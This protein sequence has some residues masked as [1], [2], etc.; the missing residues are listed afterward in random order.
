MSG[1]TEESYPAASTN[2]KGHTESSEVQEV[3]GNQSTPQYVSGF[4]GLIADQL[5]ANRFHSVADKTVMGSR[6]SLAPPQG[7]GGSTPATANH[8]ATAKSPLPMPKGKRKRTDKDVDDV[9][10]RQNKGIK[11]GKGSSSVDFVDGSN[12]SSS[13]DQSA[14]GES[15][16]GTPGGESDHRPQKAFTAKASSTTGPAVDSDED[17]SDV[18]GETSGGR[19]DTMQAQNDGVVFPDKVQITNKGPKPN[20][21]TEDR[22]RAR[23]EVQM[24]MNKDKKNI[25][26]SV[27]EA[28]IEYAMGTVGLRA[29]DFPNVHGLAAQYLKNTNIFAAGAFSSWGGNRRLKKEADRLEFVS[30]RYPHYIVTL[31]PD[32]L[33]CLVAAQDLIPKWSDP[34]GRPI[35]IIRE[36]ELMTYLRTSVELGEGIQWNGN[37]Y[38]VLMI[39][40]R[41]PDGQCFSKGVAVREPITATRNRKGIP[42]ANRT[43]VLASVMSVAGTNHGMQPYPY[44]EQKVQVPGKVM[45]E[46]DWE[47]ENSHW[48]NNLTDRHADPQ[49]LRNHIKTQVTQDLMPIIKEEWRNRLFFWTKSNYPEFDLQFEV[50]HESQIVYHDPGVQ[51]FSEETDQTRKVIRRIEKAVLDSKP[52]PKS[53]EETKRI[54]KEGTDTLFAYRDYEMGNYRRMLDSMRDHQSDTT[55]TH[56]K[57][58]ESF[59]EN[60]SLLEEEGR[61]RQIDK[62]RS[63]EVLESDL[64]KAKQDLLATDSQGSEFRSKTLEELSEY[65]ATECNVPVEEQHQW[66]K[67]LSTM[68]S[69][70]LINKDPYKRSYGKDVPNFEVKGFL[71]LAEIRGGRP[72]VTFLTQFSPELMISLLKER[73]MFYLDNLSRD[74]YEVWQSHHDKWLNRTMTREQLVDWQ[75]WQD[76][77]YKEKYPSADEIEADENE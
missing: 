21:E 2:S 72:L 52:T 6:N 14:N 33:L 73:N 24:W 57:L 11:S 25:D 42:V 54:V 27:Y 48:L 39:L 64:A 38:N 36:H 56:Q 5:R 75:R 28:M 70:A 46:T 40:G 61:K 13:K 67:Q 9:A 30:R 50:P 16:S 34:K 55:V 41:R 43:P 4:G 58:L 3:V 76:R 10:S 23:D 8:L 69:A 65:L 7:E 18:L 71:E 59:L 20:R 17:E 62:A 44:P 22:P 29:E 49:V 15:E 31:P 51:R 60:E 53:C 1:S 35:D 37:A 74:Q 68:Q 19:I 32:S 26:I 77:K 63:M 66:S 47:R 45:R 12:E